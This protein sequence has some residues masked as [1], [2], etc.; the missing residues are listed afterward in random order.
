MDMGTLGLI[1]GFAP[2]VLTLWFWLGH[3]Q[4]WW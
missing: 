3:T 2:L 1:L 4:R